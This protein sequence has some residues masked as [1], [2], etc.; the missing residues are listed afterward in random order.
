MRGE[1]FHGFRR[2]LARVRFIPACA[3][4]TRDGVRCGMGSAVHPRMRGEHCSSSCYSCKLCGSSPHARGTRSF[5]AQSASHARFIPACAGN[6]STRGLQARRA[7]GSSPHARGTRDVTRGTELWWR[8]IPACAGN[9]SAE[10]L[11]DLRGSVHP[12]MRGEHLRTSMSARADTGSSPHARGTRLRARPSF[13]LRRFI[14]A[15]AG[16]TP[17]NQRVAF[18][19]AVH[20]RMRGE[21]R[22]TGPAAGAVVGSSPHARGTPNGSAPVNGR[23]PV[24]P[25]M[26][27]EHSRMMSARVSSSGS[28][29][30]ARGTPRTRRRA[31]RGRRFIPACAGN[32][33]RCMRSSFRS[34]VHPRMR[35]EHRWAMTSRPQ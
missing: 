15:C 17:R 9:T 30:H 32:T 24:H 10:V 29:P 3:G 23:C 28:S 27:G 1:H 34:A 31:R 18:R 22:R 11:P 19:N 5:P 35:G 12:R 26:R 13:A 2:G 14:P 8:F 6:T 20:P 16:N 4:N 33:S 25:R 21:H 7:S